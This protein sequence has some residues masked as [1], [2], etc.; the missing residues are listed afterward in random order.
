MT[1]PEKTTRFRQV[2]ENNDVLV[3]GSGLGGLV[4]AIE[5]ARQGFKVCVF[6]Q[7]RVAGG[8]AHSFR[9]K[10]YHFDISLHSM[11]GLAPGQ[12][13]LPAGICITEDNT[14]FV[15]D[16]VNRRIQEFKYLADS[17]SGGSD[18]GR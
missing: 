12:F 14:I 4:C 2:P 15:A 3:I 17:G 8:Y 1:N 18:N 9:R 6:E 7:H 10:G 16:S 5:L 13:R 11:G